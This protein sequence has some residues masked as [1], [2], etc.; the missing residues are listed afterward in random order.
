MSLEGT[1]NAFE[2]RTEAETGSCPRFAGRSIGVLASGRGS[3]FQAIVDAV[4]RRDLDANVAVLIC[5]NPK[6]YVMDRAKKHGIP[7]VLVEKGALSREEF[8]D[9]I[10][11]MLRDHCVDLVVLAGFMRILSPSFVARWPHR[12]LNIHP[13][14]LPAF[15][16]AHAHRDAIAHGVKITGLTIHFVDEKVDHGPIIFQ[17]PV[18][19]LDGD[20][21]ETISQRVLIQEHLW[22]PKAIGWVLDG[23]V[24]LEGRA[25]HLS[26]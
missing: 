8:C 4:E 19:V 12:V 3:D 2:T 16:G 10:D 22:Y 5:D 26:K 20:N 21:E 23:K 14:L 18:E 1:M 17:Y 6:A 15:P 9:R 24:R 11:A 25:V 7:A 13:S